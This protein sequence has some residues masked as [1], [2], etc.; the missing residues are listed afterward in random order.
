MRNSELPF[1]SRIGVHTGDSEAYSRRAWVIFLSSRTVC[2]S[3]SFTESPSLVPR[4]GGTTW[5]V[6]GCTIIES[7]GCLAC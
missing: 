2:P 6:S 1:G 7:K 3:V 5:M 4:S